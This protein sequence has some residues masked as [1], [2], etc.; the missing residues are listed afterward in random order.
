MVWKENFLVL[1]PNSI[2]LET[3]HFSSTLII[4]IQYV[5]KIYEGIKFCKFARGQQIPFEWVWIDTC[6]INKRNSSELA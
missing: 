4:V 1:F 3:I 2:Y 6:C 5:Y